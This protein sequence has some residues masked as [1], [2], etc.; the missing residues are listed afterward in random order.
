M[1][2]AISIQDTEALPYIEEAAASLREQMLALLHE[3]PEEMKQSGKAVNAEI[4]GVFEEC[5][6]MYAMFVENDT[7]R[8]GRKFLGISVLSSL[9]CLT[10]YTYLHNSNNAELIEFVENE[11]TTEQCTTDIIDLM[12]CLYKEV[13]S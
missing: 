6:F 4:K 10:A 13:I 7:E 2:N 1:K 9:M 3:L 5:D 8:P 12:H 11:Y